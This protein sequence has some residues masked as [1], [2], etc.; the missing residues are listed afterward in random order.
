MDNE[1]LL[2]K[3]EAMQVTKSP[4]KQNGDQNPFD[5]FFEQENTNTNHHQEIEDLKKQVQ[6][7]E[8]KNQA[9]QEENK[10]SKIEFS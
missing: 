6:E 10:K 2:H 3:I 7:L 4:Q 9:S 5:D 8:H 1:S